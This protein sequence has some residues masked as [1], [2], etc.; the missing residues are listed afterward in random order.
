MSKKIHSS[1]IHILIWKK[2]KNNTETLTLVHSSQCLLTF[3][4]WEA[5][6][7]RTDSRW[8]WEWV[9]FICSMQLS[10]R[11][12]RE[13]QKKLFKVVLKDAWHAAFTGCNHH[14]SWEH[15][16]RG[17]NGKKNLEVCGNYLWLRG[18]EQRD[19]WPTVPSEQRPSASLKGPEGSSYQNSGINNNNKTFRQF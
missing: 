6:P 5:L 7:G 9:C 13:N 1:W 14:T 18:F 12:A 3:L 10:I 19:C 15:F 11:P 8:S 16:R 2:N 4:R 17:S